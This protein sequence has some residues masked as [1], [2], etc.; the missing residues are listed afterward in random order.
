MGRLSE[1]WSWDCE[2]ILG[3]YHE[4]NVHRRFGLGNLATSLCT[5][6]HA[7]KSG[8][9]IVLTERTRFVLENS[10]GLSQGQPLL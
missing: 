6:F 1:G 7:W 4:S 9:K 3:R 10:E 8:Y 2:G 5:H